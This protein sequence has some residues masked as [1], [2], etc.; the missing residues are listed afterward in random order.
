VRGVLIE[1]LYTQGALEGVRFSGEGDSGEEW[2]CLG[3][4]CCI[5]E[6]EFNLKSVKELLRNV[7]PGSDVGQ[8]YL[9]GSSV[10][11]LPIQE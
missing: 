4:M 11:G 2:N 1:V 10:C 5:E 8:I 3:T 9:L 7:K 6:S